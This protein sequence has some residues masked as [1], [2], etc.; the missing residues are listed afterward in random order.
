MRRP[1]PT[2]AAILL[3]V[4]C[5]LLVAWQRTAQNKGRL[6]GPESGIFLVMRPFQTALN[7]IGAWASDVGR[8]AFR[9][10]SIVSENE[11][12]HNEVDDLRGQTQR[13]ARY[14]AENQELRKLLGMPKPNGGNS[15][16]AEVIGFNATEIS[17]A[18]TLN[19][20][21]RA[22]VRPKDVVFNAQGVVGQVSE[23]SPF[24]ARVLPLTDRL[25]GVGAM[26][27]RTM[28]RGVLK[29]TDDRICKLSYLDYRAD[30]REGDL[31]IT[32]GASQIFPR[33]LVLGHV[34]KVER[35]KRYSQLTA[36]V[37]PA[38]VF[39]RLS[40]VYVRVRAGT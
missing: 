15:I 27:S 16:P 23:V 24:S 20:G 6:S 9:R 10:P 8:A 36:Y 21:A 3:L 14:P 38:V 13:M 37:D 35:D 29:G 2:T 32:S 26:I 28:A 30:V 19:I 25:S 39:D 5:A 34:I 1:S 4:L 18:L 40:A 7:G 17:R 22:Q 11:R 12:L 31:V 33:G